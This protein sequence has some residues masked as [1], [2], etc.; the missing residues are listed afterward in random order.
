MVNPAEIWCV[1][2]SR[3]DVMPFQ[4]I[5]LAWDG[6]NMLGWVPFYLFE[7]SCEPRNCDFGCGHVQNEKT[8]N[9]FLLYFVPTSLKNYFVVLSLFTN[10]SRPPP[11]PPKIAKN[12]S[13]PK[14]V[15]CTLYSV[16]YSGV[17]EYSVLC[18]GYLL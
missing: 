17:L 18:T 1:G 3:K 16:L 13:D 12:A 2:W 6:N 14:S 8:R 5:L 10:S 7:L 9:S 4:N 15:L 11:P